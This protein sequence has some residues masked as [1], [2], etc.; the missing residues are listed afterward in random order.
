MKQ[1]NF[2]FLKKRKDIGGSEITGSMISPSMQGV[3]SMKNL[4]QFNLNTLKKP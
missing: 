2:E 3:H 4:Q 1:K